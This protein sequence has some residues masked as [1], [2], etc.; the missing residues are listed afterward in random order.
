MKP[1]NLNETNLAT[2]K[3]HGIRSL[4]TERIQEATQGSLS[5]THFLDLLLEDEIRYRKSSRITRLLK[6]AGFRNAASCEAVEASGSRN[7]DK[8]VLAELSTCQFIRDSQSLMITGPRGR[9]VLFSHR[10][11]QCCLPPWLLDPL[12][13]DERSHG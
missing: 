5:Y 9:K 10:S 12:L 7:L 3:L 13:S 8:K 1:I 4:L 6:N 2:L 11:W